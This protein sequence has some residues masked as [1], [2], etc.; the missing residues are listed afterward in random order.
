MRRN[1]GYAGT[2]DDG[3]GANAGEGGRLG[4]AEADVAGRREKGG[5][6]RERRRRRRRRGGRGGG[7]EGMTR[8]EP[9]AIE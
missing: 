9:S 8:R 4:Q 1:L 3:E 2:G 5:R 7:G 6:R